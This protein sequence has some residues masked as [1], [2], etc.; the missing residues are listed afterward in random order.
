MDYMPGTASLAATHKGKVQNLR[1]AALR[2]KHQG[3]LAE[4]CI[5]SLEK[6]TKEYNAEQAKATGNQSHLAEYQALGISSAYYVS[7]H[8]V[9]ADMTTK[10]LYLTFALEMLCG[11]CAMMTAE[12]FNK[13][14]T[15]TNADEAYNQLSKGPSQASLEVAMMATYKMDMAAALRHIA[16]TKGIKG[17]MRASHQH[18]T[19]REHRQPTRHKRSKELVKRMMVKALQIRGNTWKVYI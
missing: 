1:L 13:L 15:S 9:Q 8:L 14:P 5:L 16:H 17:H 3:L 2:E 18:P 12:Q 10:N 11:A 19:R 6:A 7:L 4:A